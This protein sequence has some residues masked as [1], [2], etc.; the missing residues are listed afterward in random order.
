MSIV[1]AVVQQKG[2]VGKSTVSAH[3]AVEFSQKGFSVALIETD[4]QGTLNNWYELRQSWQKEI[5]FIFSHINGWK[6]SNEISKHAD[7]D[8]VII[9]SP[10]HTEAETRTIIRAADL[11]LIPMQPS[12]IDC[13]SAVTTI[14]LAE[15]ENK[16]IKVLMNR[17][18]SN[19]KISKNIRS[20]VPYKMNSYLSNRI[21]FVTSML[22]GKCATEVATNSAAAK[23]VNAVVG[24]IHEFLG[25]NFK[26]QAKKNKLVTS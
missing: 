25:N 19:T 16:P 5:S 11:V 20:Q 15:Y 24:E 17:F 8:L 6:I 26:L 2:G 3:L 14:K 10:P 18:N 1:I 4:P 12:P 13:W 21:S 7:C 23:E 9:D 22:Q